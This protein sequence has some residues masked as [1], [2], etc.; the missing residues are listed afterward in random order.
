MAAAVLGLRAGQL[1]ASGVILAGS[2]IKLTGWLLV[3]PFVVH[4]HFGSRLRPHRE[5]SATSSAC[6]V[7]AQSHVAMESAHGSIWAALAERGRR[8]LLTQREGLL[9]H[10]VAPTGCERM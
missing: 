2:V 5:T 3:A 4:L 6:D 9:C 7:A 10:R 8:A 1:V